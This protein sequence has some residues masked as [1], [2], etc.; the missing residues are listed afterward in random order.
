MCRG[1]QQC[2]VVNAADLAALGP[3]FGAPV[4]PGLAQDVYRD[5]VVD[6]FDAVILGLNYGK[7]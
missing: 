6:I 5:G 3:Y 4:A 2:G 1:Y 7:R